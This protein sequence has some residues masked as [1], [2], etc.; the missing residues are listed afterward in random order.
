[1]AKTSADSLKVRTT[2]IVI[3]RADKQTKDTAAVVLT[4]ELKLGF[5]AQTLSSIY[6]PYTREYGFFESI[7]AGIQYGWNVLAGY[8]DD[9]KYV[10]TSDGAKSLG[11]FGAIGSLFPPVWDWYLFWKMTAFL[12]II[13]AFM[14]ILPIPAL[15]GGHVL[16]LLYEAIT[17]RKPSEQFMIRA[18]YVGFG[19]LILLM[20]VANL[21]DILR[22][23]GYM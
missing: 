13:L 22:W 11:G 8:V 18:E 23:L 4:P 1:M 7:P 16:F 6:K 20:V 12:S 2:T 10:F 21:N 15:D 19:I 17:R 9:M 5:T 3:E 14:N